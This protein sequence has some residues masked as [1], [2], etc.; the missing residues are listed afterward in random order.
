MSLKGRVNRVIFDERE[1]VSFR[2]TE[3]SNHDIPNGIETA[4]E[5]FKKNERSIIQIHPKVR[6]KSIFLI[7]LGK[8]GVTLM[9]D[10][11][12]RVTD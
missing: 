11:L 8:Q 10:V 4:L 9:F 6:R 7:G 2:L 5:H 3:G 12:F 1:E